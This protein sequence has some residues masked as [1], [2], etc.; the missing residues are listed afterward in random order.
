MQCGGRLGKRQGIVNCAP[1]VHA[2]GQCPHKHIPRPVGE[3]DLNRIGRMRDIIPN[4]TR[5]PK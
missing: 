5:C 4:H 1:L 3:N 2:R